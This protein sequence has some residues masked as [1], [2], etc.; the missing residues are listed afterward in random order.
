LDWEL[1][2]CAEKSAEQW[3]RHWQDNIVPDVLACDVLLFM[4]LT[5]ERSCSALIEV[6]IALAHAKPVLA[7]SPDWWS[8]SHLPNVRSF[9][10]LEP[11]IKTL[12]AMAAGERMRNEVLARPPERAA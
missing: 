7:V 3:R 6:G 5:S 10:T 2:D 1:Q 4:S 12:I 9:T 11:A 8:F